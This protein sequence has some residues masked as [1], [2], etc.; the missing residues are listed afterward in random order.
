MRCKGGQA[1]NTAA[2]ARHCKTKE[3][4]LKSTG[5]DAEWRTASLLLE[6]QST[7]P[8]TGMKWIGAAANTNKSRWVMLLQ[9]DCSYVAS[10]YEQ[11]A[12]KQAWNR[13]IGK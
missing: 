6:E 10:A 11:G 7:G 2:L 12:L 4:P 3:L 13:T 5:S 8:R 9:I 1:R